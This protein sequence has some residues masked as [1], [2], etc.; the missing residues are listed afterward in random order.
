M[1]KFC[2]LLIILLCSINT[3][4][5]DLIDF[6]KQIWP[7]MQQSCIACHG[8]DKAKGG[9]RLDLP[10]LIT[11]NEHILKPKNTD[12]S[13]LYYR[14]IL[15]DDDGDLMPPTKAGKRLT[16]AQTDLIELWI[17]QGG[18]FGN[19]MAIVNLSEPQQTAVN[20]LRKQGVYAVRLGDRTRDIRIDYRYTPIKKSSLF[21]I[22]PAL[23]NLI[24]QLNLS[25]QT[26][27]PEQFTAITKLS[28]LEKIEFSNTNITDTDLIKFKSL[29]KLKSLNLYNTKITAKALAVFAE[30]RTL[31]KLYIAQTP[32]TPAQQK[33]LQK[34]LR[35]TKIIG[36]WVM[37]KIEAN[38]ITSKKINRKK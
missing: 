35:K 25:N 22:P 32:I 19:W 11:K 12:D 31:K 5:K 38:P 6:E 8:Q 29:K 17:N 30:S 7:I 26:L 15:D 21:S 1:N 10:E 18:K 27:T 36:N 3:Y 2:T 16:K 9:L 13:E 34:S 14:I 20:N 23:S 4:A 33:T 28:N 24:T 37:P